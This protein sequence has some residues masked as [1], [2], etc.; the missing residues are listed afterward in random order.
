MSLA[1][2]KA[3]GKKTDFSKAT[4]LFRSRILAKIYK[5]SACNSCSLMFSTHH[6][7]LKQS[8]DPI[9]KRMSPQS[10][11]W[12]HRCKSPGIAPHLGL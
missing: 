5:I 6:T 8:Y 12:R 9:Q 7:V 4:K 1:E 3:A 10:V 11:K 2:Q